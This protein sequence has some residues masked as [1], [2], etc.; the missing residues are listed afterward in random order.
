MGLYQQPSGGEREGTPGLADNHD[1]VT[2]RGVETSDPNR[3]EI[4]AARTRSDAIVFLREVEIKTERRYVIVETPQGNIGKDLIAIFD[5]QSGEIL[6]YGERKAQSIYQ[7]SMSQCARCGYAVLPAGRPVM[8][9]A[10][11]IVRV[12]ELKE[13]GVGFVCKTCHTL[14]CPF[15]VRFQEGRGAICGFCGQ[16]MDM[17][18]E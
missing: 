5:E 4:Y 1:N 3:Y 13:K 10:K 16:V 12:G 15:C 17:S 11:E 6:E 9:G 2:F 8:D 7:K 14:W 18:R